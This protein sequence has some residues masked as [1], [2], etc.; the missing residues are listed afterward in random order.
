MAELKSRHYTIGITNEI[1]SVNSV[2]ELMPI[3]GDIQMWY[4]EFDGDSADMLV[5]GM[6]IPAGK[7]I[8]HVATHD[9]IIV[10]RAVAGTVNIHEVR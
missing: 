5:K 7:L 10:M 8:E 3:D 4:G 2:R 9:G 1:K 6:V